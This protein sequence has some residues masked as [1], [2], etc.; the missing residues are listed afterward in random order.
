MFKNILQNNSDGPD[1]MWTSCVST[2]FSQ[3]ILSLYDLRC[4]TEKSCDLFYTMICLNVKYSCTYHALPWIT[5]AHTH[6]C[7][8][9]KSQS[10]H[11]T[12]A[13]SLYAFQEFYTVLNLVAVGTF[14][15]SE[16]QCFIR[17]VMVAKER[18][19]ESELS[20][21]CSVEGRSLLLLP[22][23]CRTV[24]PHD[25]CLLYYSKN[26]P[27]YSFSLCLWQLLKI[28]CP[29]AWAQCKYNGL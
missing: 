16:H 2:R 9:C 1:G 29:Y 21:E 12:L 3:Y 27:N 20:V 18:S 17:V 24:C 26:K 5:G 28:L 11:C 22:H 4:Y 25:S 8:C 23:S 7:Q 15:H 14:S 13:F 10:L 6:L 19:N